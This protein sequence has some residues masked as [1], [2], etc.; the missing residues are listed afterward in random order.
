MQKNVSILISINKLKIKQI[1]VQ[2]VTFE[3]LPI[4]NNC[5]EMNF[6]PKMCRFY[7]YNNEI[8]LKQG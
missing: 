4:V 3:N 8:I 2:L 1:F 5:H 6:H 7:Y